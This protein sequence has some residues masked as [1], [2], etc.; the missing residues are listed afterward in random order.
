MISPTA[1]KLVGTIPYCSFNFQ[2][3]TYFEL[4]DNLEHTKMRMKIMLKL[5]GNET[6]YQP[7]Y[8]S[9]TVLCKATLDFDLTYDPYLFRILLRPQF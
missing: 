6:W 3:S 2:F 9:Y 1:S 8:Q 4:W 5:P 7:W